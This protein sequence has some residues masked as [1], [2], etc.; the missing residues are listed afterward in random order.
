[1]DRILVAVGGDLF[2]SIKLTDHTDKAD[3]LWIKLV[4]QFSKHGAISLGQRAG[5]MEERETDGLPIA[6]EFCKSLQRSI[7]TSECERLHRHE[8]R[9]SD[10]GLTRLFSRE[11]RSE[12][13]R[14]CG[15]NQQ[16]ENPG[17]G[18][19]VPPDRVSIRLLSGE[20]HEGSSD[21]ENNLITK[22]IRNHRGRSRSLGACVKPSPYRPPY[23]SNTFFRA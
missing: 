20:F 21:E 13:R 2:R 8:R 15:R 18:K 1:M 11:Q 16:Q 6:H 7:D 14:R 9:C 19:R 4:G 12:R 22:R 23:F 17:H 10:V 3:S 5:R